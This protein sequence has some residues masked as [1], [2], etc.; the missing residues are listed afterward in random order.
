MYGIVI[1]NIICN[2]D[3]GII[4]GGYLK[5]SVISNVINRRKNSPLISIERENGMINVKTENLVQSE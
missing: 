5:D 2:S 4:I 3:R 1:F